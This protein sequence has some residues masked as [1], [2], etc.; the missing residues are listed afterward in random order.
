LFSQIIGN[1]TIL[2]HLKHLIINNAANINA[3]SWPNSLTHLT[4]NIRNNTINTW[5]I[6]LTH[7]NIKDFNI[8][9]I[10]LNLHNLPDTLTEITLYGKF[11]DVL[12][13]IVWPKYLDIIYDR[14]CTMYINSS[15]F[16][17][18]LRKI[19]HVTNFGTHDVYNRPIG[20]YTKAAGY[21]S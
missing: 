6:S 16:P 11:N 5:P 8:N 12:S 2:P 17:H 4:I 14:S 18:S 3:L 1:L 20:K 7:L 13:T 19:I 10:I 9:G 15:V 21:N